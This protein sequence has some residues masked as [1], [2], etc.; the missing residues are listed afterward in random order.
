MRN[1]RFILAFLLGAF[2]GL[3]GASYVFVLHGYQTE[4]VP[5]KSDRWY[6]LIKEGRLPEPLKLTYSEVRSNGYVLEVFGTIENPR[7]KPAQMQKVS[8][9]LVDAKGSFTHKCEF[10]IPVVAPKSQ[11]NF[12]FHCANISDLKPGGY[13]SSKVYIDA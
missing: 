8:A 3:L 4:Y 6:Q 12:R 1:I 11:Y 13:V 9:D 7:E 10:W 2:V 5:H